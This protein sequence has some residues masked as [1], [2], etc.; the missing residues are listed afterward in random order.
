MSVEINSYPKVYQLGHREIAGILDDAVVVEEKV[1]GSQFSFGVY[2]GQLACRS[3]R[4]MLDLD[5]PESMF[6]GAVATVKRLAPMLRDGWTYRGEVLSKPKHNTL[7][8]ERVP[9]GN[10]I[11]FDVMT[12][13]PEWYL[14]RTDKEREAE[15]LGLE[16]VPVLYRGKVESPAQLLAMLDRVS[17][18]GGQRI[19]GVVVKNNN[20][21]SADG[22]PMFG[23]Y[24]SESF[25][26]VHR[27]DYK[28]RHP[29][30]AD[31]VDSIIA[32]HSTVARWEKA[33]QRLAEE[34]KLKEDPSDIGQLMR[35]VSRDVNAECEST[36]K[37]ILWDHFRGQILAGVSN[38]L[39]EWYKRRL[40][41]IEEV[42]A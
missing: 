39:P 19:E 1:D 2:G 41:G 35:E 30:R 40:A 36:I 42:A 8:Y 25:R 10:V 22:K 31:V 28:G 32:A 29:N 21:F 20:K 5:A 12:D 6:N 7:A 23:K 13:R 9:A 3:H 37:Q 16:I 33:V 27:I 17:C 38:G 4:K 15:R 34:G 24:V 14:E 11:L 18:L 26:E